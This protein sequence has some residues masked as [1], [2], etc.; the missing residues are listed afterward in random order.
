MTYPIARAALLAANQKLCQLLEELKATGRHIGELP[1]GTVIMVLSVAANAQNAATVESALDELQRHSSPYAL[2]IA[3]L[4]CV[5]KM[6]VRT[7]QPERVERM[8]QHMKSNSACSLDCVVRCLRSCICGC[9]HSRLR[10]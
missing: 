5:V 6:Y 8:L 9:A 1:K 7:N 4:N 10:G 2:D 3:I